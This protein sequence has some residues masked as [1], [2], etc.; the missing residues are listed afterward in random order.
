MG[1]D[2]ALSSSCRE[3]A[4]KEVQVLIASELR[5]LSLPLGQPVSVFIF[6]RVITRDPSCPAGGLIVLF[7]CLGFGLLHR[8]I[9]KGVVPQCYFSIME[10]CA[11]SM[12]D[13]V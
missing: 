6:S 10:L 4:E 13:K 2:G 3:E 1:A 9:D 7:L 11:R 12:T 8:Y 5:S